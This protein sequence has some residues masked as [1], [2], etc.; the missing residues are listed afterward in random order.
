MGCCHY[1]YEI[2]GCVKCIDFLDN[3]LPFCHGMFPMKLIWGVRNCACYLNFAECL[4][5]RDAT[6]FKYMCF[7][8][9]RNFCTSF[10]S[11]HSNR[12]AERNTNPVLI[13]AYKIHYE[14]DIE[15]YCILG[16]EDM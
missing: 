14:P 9:N 4:Y 2:S 12:I 5:E 15:N 8:V 7:E 6:R 3:L 10:H 11:F 1:G 13:V 16:N